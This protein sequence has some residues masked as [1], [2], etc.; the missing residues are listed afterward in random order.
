MVRVVAWNPS[1]GDEF[2]A[3]STGKRVPTGHLIWEFLF[4]III[5]AEVG[6]GCMLGCVCS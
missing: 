6:R 3:A 4:I 5:C 1:T 2:S